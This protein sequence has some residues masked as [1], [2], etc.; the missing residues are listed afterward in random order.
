MG[1]RPKTRK[2]LVSFL[3][4]GCWPER[5]SQESNKTEGPMVINKNCKDGR[6]F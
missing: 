3:M 2:G 4:N 6:Y 5:S 1:T